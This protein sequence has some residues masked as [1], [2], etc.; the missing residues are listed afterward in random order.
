VKTDI[1]AIS[2][3]DIFNIEEEAVTATSPG[4][5]K[6]KPAA[7]KEKKKKP[8]HVVEILQGGSK[9]KVEF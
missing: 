5:S 6:P 7:E 4:D 8:S 3:N 2:V 1:D 9:T